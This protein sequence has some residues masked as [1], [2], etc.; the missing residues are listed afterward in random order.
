MSH[1]LV[2]GCMNLGGAWGQERIPAAQYDAARDAVHAA[3]RAGYTLFDH[4][5]IYIGGDSETVFGR[6]IGED[7]VLRQAVQVQTKCGIR[8]PGNTAP[9]GLPPTTGWTGTPSAPRS[10]VPCNGS[11]WT[12][13]SGCSCT[14]RIP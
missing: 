1:S 14:A 4:A 8:L 2:F 6:I 11:G 9:A 5:D 10:R 13:W 12:G 7:A 3:H